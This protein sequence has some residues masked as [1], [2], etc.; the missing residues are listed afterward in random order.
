MKEKYVYL[1]AT[2][3]IISCPAELT[4]KGFKGEKEKKKSYH[5]GVFLGLHA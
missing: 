4:F 2:R 3:N 1:M 5:G